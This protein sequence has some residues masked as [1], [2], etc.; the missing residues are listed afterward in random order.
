MET[1]TN[2]EP[3]PAEAVDRLV[4]TPERRLDAWTRTVRRGILAAR[5]DGR[6]YYV[7]TT[8]LAY[9]V[10]AEPQPAGLRFVAHADG[11]VEKAVG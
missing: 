4:G 1:N 7:G 11:R 10:E 5:R 2:T 9:Y 6:T 8:A 3:M